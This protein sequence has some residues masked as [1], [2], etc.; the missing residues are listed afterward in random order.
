[1]KRA[2]D[3]DL[4][5]RNQPETFDK[6]AGLQRGGWFEFVGSDEK[7]TLPSLAYFADMNFAAPLLVPKPFTP[8]VFHM[9]AHVILYSNK[10]LT[11]HLRWFPTL[12]ITVQFLAPI[13][14]HEDGFAPRTIGLYQAGGFVSRPDARHEER[15]EIWTAPEGFDGGNALDKDWRD[16][17]VCLCVSTQMALV[18]SGDINRKVGSK[19]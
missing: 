7:L 3:H 8:D 5:A 16:K 19:L 18:V 4:T 12:V 9:Y 17:Q 15:V 11:L 13:S 2:L 1:V 6:L 14:R 10:V